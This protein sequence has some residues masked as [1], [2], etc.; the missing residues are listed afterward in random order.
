[1]QVRSAASPIV[2]A[3]I[4]PSVVEV[5]PALDETSVPRPARSGRNVSP[6]AVSGRRG[7]RTRTRAAARPVALTRSEEYRFI[8]S[9]L[10]RL[11]ITASL[12]GAV[13]IALLFI[14]EM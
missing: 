11:L 7:G 4:V 1:M 14:L 9:D 5:D 8:R 3:P 6:S 13:M 12:L 2:D 10:H